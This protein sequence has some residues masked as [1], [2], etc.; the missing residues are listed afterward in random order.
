M[1]I[2]VVVPIAALALVCGCGS[3]TPLAQPETASSPPTSSPFALGSQPA[4]PTQFATSANGVAIAWHQYGHGALA[5]VL[6]HGWAADS[7]IWQSQLSALATRFT[8]VTLDLGGQGASGTNREAW[9]PATYAQDVAAVV[10][11]LPQAHVVLVGQGMGGP[12]ALTAA[13]LIGARLVGIV[14]VETFRTL[15]HPPP[16]ASQIEQALQP[17]RTDFAG[18]LK[19]FVA[20]TLFQPRSDPAAV[21]SVST[22]M[23]Q[24]D[25][26]RG[27]AALDALNRFDYAAILPAVKVPVT[28]I[29]SEL[30]GPLDE[31]R[32]HRAVAQLRIITLKG[33]DSFPMLDDTVRF[34][35]TLLQAID[36]LASP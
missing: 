27:V 15:G 13:P 8:V 28:L 14:G 17:F 5:V 21:R 1:K 4:A 18:S 12:V 11:A 29:D 36:S 22:L 20:G 31:A 25:P 7:R 10:A 2:R 9:S 33:D 34:N 19:R 24:T 35:S 32:M 30:A 23:A 16:F 3:R 26:G 6:I